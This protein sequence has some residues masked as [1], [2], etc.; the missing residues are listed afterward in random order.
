M[1][2]ILFDMDGVLV[3]SMPYH[4]EAWG[5]ILK[6][7]GINIEKKL[8]Y[9][10]EGANSRQVIDAIFRQFGRIPTDEEIQEITRKK[11]EIFEQ[12]AQVK[13]FD[14]IQE[15][16]ETVKSKCKLAVVSGSHR[17][18]VKKTIDTFFPDTFEVVIDGEETKIS[19]PSPEPYLIA[20]RKLHIPKDHCLVVENAPLGIRS[21]KSAGLRCIAI[22]TYLGRE[23]LKEADW[24]AEN[25]REMIAYI[26]RG[27]ANFSL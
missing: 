14:G 21:A 8:I 12:I 10:L 2:A 15:F 11:L 18:T 4:A 17:Q 24:I 3:D 9:E 23:Y 7:V 19:K 22:T 25:H 26:Q 1:Q 20:V 5:M 27:T 16:L 6:T 13:P